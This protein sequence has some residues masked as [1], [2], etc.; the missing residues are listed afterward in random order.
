MH[1]TLLFWAN[2]IFFFSSMTLQ[3]LIK[4]EMWN[5][6]HQKPKP[7]HTISYLS[8]TT[9]HKRYDGVLSGSASLY[10]RR[11]RKYFLLYQ[12]RFVEIFSHIIFKVKKK[13]KPQFVKWEHLMKHKINVSALIS[14]FG[15]FGI[16]DPSSCRDFCFWH[17][18]CRSTVPPLFLNVV[19]DLAASSIWK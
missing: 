8:M 9:A 17:C 1:S 14:S 11:S 2:N 7:Y 4:A 19:A 5:F 6:R 10:T 16:G 12:N 3:L 18:E 15:H 13:I